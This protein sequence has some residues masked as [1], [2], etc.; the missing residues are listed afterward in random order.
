MDK[1]KIMNDAPVPASA[2]PA[3]KNRL[4]WK[5]GLVYLFMLLLVMIILDIYVV[6]ALRLEYQAAAF[7]QLESLSRVA[8]KKP[9]KLQDLSALREWTAWLSQSGIRVT[10]ISSEGK[11]LADSDE[12]PARMENHSDRP[13]ILNALSA[14]SG[15]A[16]RYSAT[17]RRDLV[18]FARRFD[19]E[20]G[21]TLV[22]RFALPLYRLDEGVNAFRTRLWSVSL[23]ILVLTGG[24][25][26]LFFRTVSN[27]IG[28]LNEFSRRVAQGDFRP[29]FIERSN[30]ELSDLSRT[31]NQT[32]SKLDQTIRTLTEERNQSAA[33]LASMEEGVAV[34]DSAQR[35]IYCN[36]AFRQAAGIPEA[37]VEG[38]LVVE[39]I[40]H[41]DLLTLIDS[42]LTKAEIIHG[43][44]VVGSVRT[45]SFA[46]TSAP[47]SSEGSVIGAVM[48]LHDISEIRRLERARR[49]FAANISHEFR[50]PLA[51]IQ[52]FAETLLDGALDDSANN[53]RFIQIIHDNAIRLGR[54]TEDLLKLARIEAG[55]LQLEIQPVAIAR[56]IESSIETTRVKADQRNLVVESNC[57]PDLPMLK[58]DARALQEI[59]LNLLDN[60][61]RYS[62][63]GGRIKV[64]AEI[65]GMEM[66]LS[67]SDA[68]IGIPKADQDRIFERFYRADAARSRE[69]GG[70]G[71]GLSITK[72]LIEAHGGRIKV[73]SEVG[74]GSTFYVFLPLET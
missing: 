73:E 64:S 74:R 47:I 55:Q 13:E 2:M 10:L 35:I 1:R 58:G 43:E 66:M 16:V 72:H 68:G 34:I 44:V 22:M 12:D 30:D 39:I 48:V 24:A 59:L 7:S 29:M 53:R 23:L 25:S 60:A 62:S 8:L 21:Q 33:I 18:Y 49:D 40:Q 37:P 57:K 61:I 65:A 71:L 9:P 63:P 5:I 17:L 54:L 14:G 27:R 20:S 26:L 45:R 52:G 6:R 69:S 67:V 56:I 41:A 70:T 11:V 19:S 38:R 15:Y 36:R 28:R 32:A 3:S 50:T 42:A 51:A 46:V 31:L 4:F